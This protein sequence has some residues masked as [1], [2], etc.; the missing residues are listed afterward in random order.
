MLLSKTS[1][2][3]WIPVA[4]AVIWRIRTGND[5]GREGC[6]TGR[7]NASAF[8]SVMVFMLVSLFVLACA[9]GRCHL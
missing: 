1:S 7:A 9:A 6:A 3:E 2:K 5:A 8:G 4:S